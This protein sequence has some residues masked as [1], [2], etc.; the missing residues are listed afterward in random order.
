[1]DERLML[2][3]L[4]ELKGIR[5]E[6]KCI[7]EELEEPKVIKLCKEKLVKYLVWRSE[8]TGAFFSVGIYSDR[9]YHCDKIEDIK[10]LVD[11]MYVLKKD[12][13]ITL[14]YKDDS[15]PKFFEFSY[16]NGLFIRS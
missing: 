5:E 3:F 16:N 2:M 8:N 9:Y 15:V 7:K 12:L 1:M 11:L 6:L 4:D 14:Y 10:E 13:G